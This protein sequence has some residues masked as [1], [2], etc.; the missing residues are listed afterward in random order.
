MQIGD[1]GDLLL[2]IRSDVPRASRAARRGRVAGPR[3]SGGLASMSV[4]MAHMFT[5]LSQRARGTRRSGSLTPHRGQRPSACEELPPG[6]GDRVRAARGPGQL[7]VR[8]GDDDP[9]SFQRAEEAGRDSRS[10]TLSEPSS[11]GSRSSI[12]VPVGRPVGQDDEERGLGQP[13]NPGVHD[14]R[15]ESTR[16]RCRCGASSSHSRSSIRCT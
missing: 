12:Y 15:G 13:A 8:G 1:V 9:V 2:E 4:A 14:P 6:I 7:G 10:S 3:A 11:A 16:G 5:S